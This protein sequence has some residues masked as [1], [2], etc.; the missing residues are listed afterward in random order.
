MTTDNPTASFLGRH[1]AAYGDGGWPAA[2]HADAMACRD[3]EER[4]AYGLAMHRLVMDEAEAIRRRLAATGA[5]YDLPAAKRVE[6][7]LTLWLAPAADALAAVEAAEGRG[8]V[9]AGAAA[10]REAVLDAR[11]STSV[12]V[13]RAAAISERIAREGLTRGTTT[14]ELRRERLQRRMG[15]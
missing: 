5:A 15:S 2:D 3:L 10:F 4:L 1:V 13:E 11:V 12:P 14:E 7:L 6:Q 8:F 9:V